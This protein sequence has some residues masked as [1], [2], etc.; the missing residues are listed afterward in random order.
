MRWPL[1]ECLTFIA[2]TPG[3]RI[4]IGDVECGGSEFKVPHGSRPRFLC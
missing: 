1:P 4:A 2:T 3:F